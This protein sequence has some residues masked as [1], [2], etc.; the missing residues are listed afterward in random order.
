MKK[1]LII[2]FAA[3]LV[4][5]ATVTFIQ[6]NKHRMTLAYENIEAL[7]DEEATPIKQC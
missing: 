7:T 1:H 6:V 4:A 3:C 2:A 5:A